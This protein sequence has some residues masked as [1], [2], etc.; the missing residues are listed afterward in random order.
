[1]ETLTSNSGDG[2]FLGLP[3]ELRDIV[4][5]H[6]IN[7][8]NDLSSRIEHWWPSTNGFMLDFPTAL[9]GVSSIVRDEAREYFYRQNIW[10]IHIVQC[11]GEPIYDISRKLPTERSLIS[12]YVLSIFVPQTSLITVIQRDVRK[13]CEALVA[14]PRI[15]TLEIAFRETGRLEELEVLLPLGLLASH[16]DNIVVRKFDYYRTFYLLK[17]VISGPAK[18]SI[19]EDYWQYTSSFMPEPL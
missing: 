6:L 1:M 10:C 4:Y 15:K 11:L 9:L 17:H 13:I 14:G 18:W 8:R 3:R 12:H 2:S 7:S 5:S 16:V 19:P